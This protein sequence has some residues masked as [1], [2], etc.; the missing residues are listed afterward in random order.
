MVNANEITIHARDSKK[1]D[2]TFNVQQSVLYRYT[3]RHRFILLKDKTFSLTNLDLRTTA[4]NVFE[5]I[6][7]E[8]CSCLF[9]WLAETYNKQ[10]CSNSIESYTEYID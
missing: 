7:N 10:S 8:I 1:S 3:N 4:S 6:I 2:I 5:I 9:H